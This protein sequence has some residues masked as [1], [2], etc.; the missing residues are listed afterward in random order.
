MGVVAVDSHTEQDPSVLKI[1]ETIKMAPKVQLLYFDGRGRG[2]IIRMILGYGGVEFEDKRVKME[3]WP[4]VKPTTKCGFMPELTWDDKI[5]VQSNAITRF[6]AREVGIA[7]KNNVEM[8]QCDAVVDF[9]SELAEASVSVKFAPDEEKKKAAL[10]KFNGKLDGF[11][12]NIEKMLEE[13]GGEW[14]VGKEFTWADLYVAV[15]LFQWTESFAGVKW[16]EKTPKLLALNK[17][18]LDLPK[19]KAHMESRPDAPF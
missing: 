14:M 17:K 12:K 8:A 4:Q 3:E 15:A 16:E 5:M 18:V 6:V 10:E 9:C 11:I 7:G 1:V 19:I 13:N 2:E